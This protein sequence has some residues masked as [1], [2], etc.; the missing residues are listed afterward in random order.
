M[1]FTFW[2]LFTP[3]LQA[4]LA[5]I[6]TAINSCRPKLSKISQ[7][8][9][10]LSVIFALFFALN[11]VYCILVTMMFRILDTKVQLNVFLRKLNWYFHLLFNL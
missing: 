2:L 10:A 8:L 7:K 3:T 6:L 1:D 5:Q 11:N 4:F 9:F